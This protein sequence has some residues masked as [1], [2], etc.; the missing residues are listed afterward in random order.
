MRLKKLFAAI[1][2]STGVLF[3][4]SA[5][6]TLEGGNFDQANIA[7][8]DSLVGW[9]CAVPWY[10]T[11][12]GN[13]IAVYID[14]PAGGGGWLY[15]EFDLNNNWGNNYRPD[16]AAAGYCGGYQYSGW[17]ASGWFYQNRSTPIYVYYKDAFAGGALTFL[18]SKTVTGPGRF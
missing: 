3:S 1:A 12:Q 11:P 6:A 16:V 8:V 2:A 13:K 4:G 14:G 9:A 18:G 15:G 17:T 7:M 5:L 10:T